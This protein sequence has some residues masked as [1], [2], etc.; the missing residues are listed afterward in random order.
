MKY[1]INVLEDEIKELRKMIADE[2]KGDAIP[3]IIFRMKNCISEIT[4]A[5]SLLKAGNKNKS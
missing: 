2:E 4:D 1:T 5:I 3:E